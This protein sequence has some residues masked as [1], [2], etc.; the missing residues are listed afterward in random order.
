M[1][2]VGETKDYTMPRGNQASDS[3]ATLFLA[4]VARILAG[5]DFFE[6]IDYN[7]ELQKYSKRVL[8]RFTP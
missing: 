7:E 8:G 4:E 5:P 1:M 3:D 6:P 2:P